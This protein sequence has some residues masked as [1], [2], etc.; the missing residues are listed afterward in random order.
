MLQRYPP[1]N[2]ALWFFITLLFQR[3]SKVYLSGTSFD[4][5]YRQSSISVTIG[6]SWYQAYIENVVNRGSMWK[7]AWA[8]A[9][10]FLGEGARTYFLP[11]KQQKRYYFPRKSLKTYYF[12]PALAGQGGARA[13]PCPP[14]RTPM[15]LCEKDQYFSLIPPYMSFIV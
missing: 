3:L 11:K 2:W 5:R 10:F 7:Y 14:L 1:I 6:S 8:S 12:W 9:D 4:S 15:K 13:P